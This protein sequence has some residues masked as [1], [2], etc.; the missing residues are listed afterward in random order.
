MEN[1]EIITYD[2]VWPV[3]VRKHE[4]DAVGLREL[5]RSSLKSS[6][7]TRKE[8]ADKLCIPQTEVDHW[9]R[10]DSYFA[11][12]N[13]EIWFKLKQVLGIETNKYDAQVTEFIEKDCTYDMQNR[14]YDSKGISPTLTSTDTNK[15]ILDVPN[16]RAVDVRNSKESEVN[17]ALQSKA[18]NNLNSNNVVRQQY[19]VRRLTPTEAERLMGLPDGWTLVDDKTCSD[20]ARYKALGNG[21]AQPCVDYI[22]RRIVEEVNEQEMEREECLQ[23][24]KTQ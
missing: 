17:G 16:E 11:V 5:L 6:G 15:T 14:I 20:S 4:V 12:P 13:A 22:L 19:A 8:L 24:T 7:L 23:D 1:K 18:S 2:V 21:L 9:F 10:T 3:S